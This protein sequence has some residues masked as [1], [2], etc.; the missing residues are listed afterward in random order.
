MPES[1]SA[2]GRPRASG[3]AETRRVEAFSDGVFAIVVTLLVLD[4]K[5]PH[6]ASGDA[7]VWAALAGVLPVF[8]AWL[9]SFAFVLVIWVNHHYL[10]DQ[11]ERTDRALMWLNGLLLFGIS[12]VP[13]P[14]A[15]A[16]EYFL[17]RPGLVLLSAAMFV[18]STSFSALRWYADVAGLTHAHVSAALRRARLRR[19]LLGPALYALAIV[20]AFAWPPG[21]LLLQLAVPVLFVVRSPSLARPAGTGGAA[22]R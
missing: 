11:I 13:F 2:A 17:G 22:G 1:E 7:A 3:L 20:L 16:G 9:I 12:F 18:I 21:A 5:I 19:S 10:F 4:L 8:L 15:L 14:T 6:V